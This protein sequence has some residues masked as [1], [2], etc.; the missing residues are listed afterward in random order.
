[1]EIFYGDCKAWQAR[2]CRLWASTSTKNPA[3]PDTMYIDNLIAKDTVNTVPP[4]T[5]MDFADHGTTD[6]MPLNRLDEATETLDM[7]A[8]VGVDLDQ[9]T[10]P[11]GRCRGVC[12]SV[13]KPA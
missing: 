8:E 11:G 7:L 6:P 2:Q 12:R 9:I 4:Q 13:R 10:Y 1:M 5:L 3:Y